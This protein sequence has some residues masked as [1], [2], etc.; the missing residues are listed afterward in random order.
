M[1]L[2]PDDLARSL[3]F[4]V[5]LCLIAL[6]VYGSVQKGQSLQ[7]VCDALGQDDFQSLSLHQWETAT[8]ECSDN[9][10]ADFADD[11]G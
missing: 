10:P 7:R 1:K 3:L 6:A 8:N 11:N 4:W 5:A 9:E 2:A